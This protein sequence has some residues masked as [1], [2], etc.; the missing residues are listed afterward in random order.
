MGAGID[1]D[2]DAGIDEDINAGLD[3]QDKSVTDKK[4]IRSKQAE[5]KAHKY[6]TQAFLD[7]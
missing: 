5:Y 6:K 2:I 1:V 4:T 7:Q 3:A